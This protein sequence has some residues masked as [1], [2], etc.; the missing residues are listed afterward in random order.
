MLR[1]FYLLGMALLFTLPVLAQTKGSYDASI[2]Y[3]S[4][5]DHYEWILSADVQ[6]MMDKQGQTLTVAEVHD[7]LYAPNIIAPGTDQAVM[8]LLSNYRRTSDHRLAFYAGISVGMMDTGALL[9]ELKA[10]RPVMIDFKTGYGEIH[11]PVLITGIEF[12]DS[13]KPTPHILKLILRDPAAANGAA[14]GRIEIPTEKLSTFGFCV[15]AC[16]TLE[17]LPMF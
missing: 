6:M 8:Q 17:A 4:T 1:C 9:K 12:D 2:H 13:T 3:V 15:R 16:Y 7:L 14:N 10:G 5:T 11:H